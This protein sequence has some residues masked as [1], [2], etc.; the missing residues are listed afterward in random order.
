MIDNVAE[1]FRLLVNAV[2][3]M[4]SLVGYNTCK[5]VH[6]CHYQTVEQF[7]HNV[8]KLV[9]VL[10]QFELK[11]WLI[12]ELVKIPPMF[13]YQLC[14]RV[15]LTVSCWVSALTPAVRQQF[16]REPTSRSVS[17]AAAILIPD[18]CIKI[19]AKSCMQI[20]RSA[21]PRISVQT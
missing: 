15:R 9:F 8:W 19:P 13:L 16:Y 7:M 17:S 5:H 12:S 11:R 1:L 2:I 6:S 14:L 18:K 21:G 4:T 20:M 3:P 10:L